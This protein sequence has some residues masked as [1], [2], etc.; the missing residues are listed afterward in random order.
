MLVRLISRSHSCE[1]PNKRSFKQTKLKLTTGL[2]AADTLHLVTGLLVFKFSFLRLV[3]WC[4]NKRQLHESII[5]LVLK[6]N[7]LISEEP[8]ISEL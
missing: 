8:F 7:I 3:E 5:F 1:V 6:L 4:K 2:A